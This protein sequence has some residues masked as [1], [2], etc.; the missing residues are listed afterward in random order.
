MVE[1]SYYLL[2]AL[3]EQPL[4]RENWAVSLNT[5][6]GRVNAVED[7]LNQPKSSWYGTDPVTGVSYGKPELSSWPHMRIT[8]SGADSRVYLRDRIDFLRSYGG[9]PEF[10][11][12]YVPS[13]QDYND[14]NYKCG[15]DTRQ[16]LELLQAIG[17]V[18]GGSSKK[19]YYVGI[20]GVFDSSGSHVDTSYSVTLYIPPWVRYQGEEKNTLYIY[21][22]TFEKGYKTYESPSVHLYH[23]ARMVKWVW[24]KE[25]VPGTPPLYFYDLENRLKQGTLAK[26]SFSD[27]EV[28]ESGIVSRS[29]AFRMFAKI[30]DFGASPSSSA[31]DRIEQ[32]AESLLWFSNR[33][34][35]H[36]ESEEGADYKGKTSY[37]VLGWGYIR[38]NVTVVKQSYSYTESNIG[39]SHIISFSPD[40]LIGVPLEGVDTQELT[41]NEH[42]T[43]VDE[44]VKIRSSNTL[45]SSVDEFFSASEGTSGRYVWFTPANDIDTLI[46]LAT[47]PGSILSLTEDQVAAR[48][49]VSSEGLSDLCRSY[50]EGIEDPDLPASLSVIQQWRSGYQSFNGDLE[51]TQVADLGLSTVQSFRFSANYHDYINAGGTIETKFYERPPE[52]SS[53]SVWIAWKEP[54]IPI[55]WPE[56]LKDAA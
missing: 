24:N 51:N 47:H 42:V 55:N 31:L 48:K 27:F 46:Y 45:P 35:D 56:T 5:I 43:G 9:A 21:G 16:L 7:L 29:P 13:K 26:D 19:T 34:D 33:S 44:D 23:T 39:G 11:W 6:M 20:S 25:T 54:Y 1:F 50:Y 18:T 14:A 49:E 10:P 3:K 40:N 12:E 30:F 4:V 2:K 52:T 8:W 28:T 22:G 53:G 17:R 37:D 38:A 41:I 36:N 15:I 32:E